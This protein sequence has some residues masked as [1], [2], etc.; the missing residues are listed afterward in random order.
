MLGLQLLQLHGFHN[1]THLQKATRHLHHRYQMHSLPIALLLLL[2]LLM[3]LM[4]LPCYSL[5]RTCY[6][7]QYLQLRPFPTGRATTQPLE[8]QQHQST[9]QM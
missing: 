2:P 6:V 7:T 4:L 1:N 8:L 3:L 5:A 9:P